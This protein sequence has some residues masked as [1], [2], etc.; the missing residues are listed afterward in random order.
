L[1]WK[2]KKIIGRIVVFGLAALLLLFILVTIQQRRD[3]HT[4]VST[5]GKY[6]GY[7]VASYNGT[8]RTSDYLTLS[9]GTRLA[10]DL[11]IPTSKGVPADKPLP[12]LFKYT[13]Y[14]RTWTVFDK[15]GKFLLG[16]FGLDLPTRALLYLRHWLAGKQGRIL[17]PLFRDRWL[18]S[19]V[20]HGYIV[21]S[22]ERPGTGASFASPTPGSMETAVKFEDEIIDWIAAQPWSDGNLAMYGDSQ[23]A[24]VQFTAAATNNP[25][26][27]AI[28]PSASDIEIYQAV[29]YPGGV[30]NKAFAS[31]YAVVPL[32]DRLATPVDS[33]PDGVLLDQARESRENTVG[34]QNAAEI[35][36][37]CPYRDSTT[38]DGLNPWQTMDLYPFIDR[39]NQSNT[40]VYLT[41]G[42]Y[43]IFTADM[44]YW[45]NNLSL[46]RKL[47][48]RPTDHSQVSANLAD[49]NYGT[50]ALRWLDYWL[51]GIDNGIMDEPPIHYY[52]QTGAK[53][54]VWQ[55][56]DQWPLATQQLTRYYF[57]PGKTGSITSTNDGSL[58]TNLSADASPADPYTVDYSVTTG[59]K[60]RWMAV[61]ETHAYP[62][63]RTHDA[64]S[65]TYTTSPLDA[66]AQ[67]AGHPIVHLWLTT[68]ALDL[69]V[70]IY[71]EE[72]S[73]SGKSK[74]LTEGE[75]RA[76]HRKLG[77]APF[78]NLGL[79][80]QSH[81]QVDQEPLPAGKP[82]ELVFS[83]LPTAYQLPAG[84][85]LR[86]TVAFADAG[87][88]DTPVLNPAPALQLLRDASHPSYVEVPVIQQNP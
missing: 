74:Y 14:G 66:D 58:V 10:Y 82:F 54:G 43:D 55:N 8:Q 36:M 87:N 28:L 64:K 37:Q 34:V 11:I 52:V 56:S 18:G 48:V 22:V 3:Q 79:P 86:V 81:Y 1:S 61:D 6:Q 5:F 60:S 27:K 53:K 13:P 26:L 23:Q 72:V 70:F 45:Y 31:I 33:D 75:L 17:D 25:H 24:M 44:F 69:D 12:V 38:P 9:D 19:V 73:P 35:A 51:K 57:G 63:L 62:D 15:N 41:V 65:L 47:T 83:L 49:L 32:L 42:W 71:L 2:M 46:P 59:A 67:I 29:E 4:M 78:D 30:F 85:R 20:K 80:F 40:A 88:F 7:S 16:D 68:D 50:E 76:S 39:I 21:F 84:S 77:Q